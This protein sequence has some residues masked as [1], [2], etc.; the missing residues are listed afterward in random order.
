[1]FGTTITNTTVTITKN[2]TISITTVTI[3]TTPTV[4]N[5]DES[6]LFHLPLG[7]PLPPLSLMSDNRPD[8]GLEVYCPTP[9]VMLSF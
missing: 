9:G 6:V 5:A 1:M 8:Q 2:T 7:F 3:T 4:T